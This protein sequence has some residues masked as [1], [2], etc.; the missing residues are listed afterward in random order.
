M[1]ENKLVPGVVNNFPEMESKNRVYVSNVITPNQE[2]RYGMLT[3]YGLHDVIHEPYTI[4]TGTSFLYDTES[5]A[6]EEGMRFLS[7]QSDIVSQHIRNCQEKLQQL[8]YEFE[9]LQRR[10][11]NV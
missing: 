2:A 9:H 5:E 10:K 11:N 3:V 8:R 6:L 4:H 7:T 1:S